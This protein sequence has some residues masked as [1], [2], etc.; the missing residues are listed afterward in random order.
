MKFR[1]S[2]KLPLSVYIVF[3]AVIVSNI[4]AAIFILNYLS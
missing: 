3:V 4:V 1:L 2:S